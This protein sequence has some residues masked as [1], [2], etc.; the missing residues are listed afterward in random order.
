MNI[1]LQGEFQKHDDSYQ[2]NLAKAQE[3]VCAL[4]HDGTGVRLNSFVRRESVENTPIA[5]IMF[6]G[7]SR[8][9]V[10]LIVKQGETEQQWWLGSGRGVESQVDYPLTPPLWFRIPFYD[11]IFSWPLVR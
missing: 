10:T 4:R 7:D 5:R 2:G 6:G 3:L 8:Q 1:Q 11:R 9:I